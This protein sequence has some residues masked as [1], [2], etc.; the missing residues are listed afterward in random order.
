MRHLRFEPA[1]GTEPGFFQK[2]DP[3]GHGLSLWVVALILFALPVSVIALRKMELNNDVQSWLP[4]EDPSAR[5]FAWCHEHFPEKQTV[6]LTWDG[7]TLDDP[8]IAL[9]SRRLKGAPSADGIIRDANPYVDSVMHAGNLLLQM[10][11]RGV[12]REEAVRRLQGTFLGKGLMKVRLTPAGKQRRDE[13]QAMMSAAAQE[14]LQLKVTTLPPVQVWTPDDLELARFNEAMATLEGGDAEDTEEIALEIPEHDF[15]VT[16]NGLATDTR[17][18]AKFTKLVSRF[19][20]PTGEPLVESCFFSPG[21]PVSMVIA[22]SPAGDAEGKI[23]LESIRQAAL[24]SFIPDDNLMLGGTLVSQVALNEGVTQAT[25]NPHADVFYKKSVMG[26]SG[27]VGI[28][29]ALISLKS[30]RLG[31]LVVGVSYY[32]ALV[33]MALIPLTGSSMNMVLVVLPTLLMVLALSGAI[34]VAN[35]WKHAVWENPIGAVDR[36]TKMAWMP[37]GLAAF[38]TALGLISLASSEL[39]PVRLFGI[40]AAI[41]TML[42]VAM[43]LYGLPSLLQLAPLRRVRPQDVNSQR[44]IRFGE[45]MGQQWL[46]LSAFTILA[47]VAAGYGLTRF[48]I[49]TKVIKYFPEN[50]RIVTDYER[51]ENS[52]A[53]ICPV[54][55]V[56]RF[57]EDAQNRSPFLE[58]MEIVRQVEEAVRKHRDVSGTISLA[59]FLPERMPPA[60][61]AST[62]EK[63]FYNRRSSET[64]KRCKQGDVLGA[65][66]FLA[67]STVGP[68]GEIRT[69]QDELWRINA[70]C[71][72]LGDIDYEHLTAELGATASQILDTVEGSDHLVTG[73][74]PLFLQTQKAV[75]NSLIYSFAMAFGLI[76]IVMVISL[77]DILAG[78]IS[79]IPNLLPVISVFGLVSWCGQRVDIGTMVTASVALGIA[80]DGTLHLI[81]W[82]RDGLTKGL[83]R[84]DAMVAALAHCGPAMW[85]TSAAVG[86]GL[87]VLYPADLLL[88]SRFGW[89][90][91]S[92]IGAA[93]IGDV[94]LLPCLLVGP[95][96]ALIE[97]GVKRRGEV[98]AASPTSSVS[99]PGHHFGK[100]QQRAESSTYVG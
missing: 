83:S 52:L 46:P 54:E 12:E 96:G 19:T 24:D 51:I 58:R 18:Q 98:V 8:R 86:M 71:S 63:I 62:R 40:Y 10:E 68:F 92:L 20:D 1:E 73:T 91:A 35:Y 100:S 79:M 97:R 3:W 56:V 95:L 11:D 78:A 64:E 17:M 53:G 47:A 9:L 69:G 93:L 13:V 72:V 67:E 57:D 59:S 14:Q 45:W 23:A 82:F 85:Q 50:S 4:K 55:V 90:M 81:T 33:G 22:L 15:R 99:I 80:V 49:E 89:L 60:E 76:A 25:W 36:A 21:S 75:L 84:Q 77:K 94:I 34:H 74:V 65:S 43:V 37:C 48:Q 88:I 30:L 38:T 2:K 5:E 7:S 27:L 70:Q 31:L 39:M 44:W 42:S 87:L 41:G 29:F 61:D 28:L 66:Q 16:W 26:L 32:S 6:V